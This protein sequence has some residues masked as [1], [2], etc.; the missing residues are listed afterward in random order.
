MYVAM[1]TNPIGWYFYTYKLY[2]NITTYLQNGDWSYIT[3]LSMV[4]RKTIKSIYPLK[5]SL[6]Q[7]FLPKKL[8]EIH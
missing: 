8:T 7:A 2:T 5:Y 4:A 6:R 3:I 1:Y